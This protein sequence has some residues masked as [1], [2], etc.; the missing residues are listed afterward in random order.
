MNEVIEKSNGIDSIFEV[1]EKD[2]V[3]KVIENSEQKLILVDF[4]APWCG[5]CKQLGP[6]LEEIT[7]KYSE[8]ISLAKINID[9]NQQLAAQLRIQS[10]P[11]VIAFKDKK[12]ADG[13][14]GVIPKKNIIEFIEK[15][16]G[17]SLEKN[18]NEFYDKV[19]NLISQNEILQAVN[20]LEDFISKNS[21]D[22]KAIHFYINSLIELKKFD[23]AENFINSLSDE[24]LKNKEIQQSITN[25]EMKQKISSSPSVEELIKIY[26]NE[27]N[28]IN[29]LLMLSDRY[30][31][32]KD[33]EKAFELLMENFIKSKG[34]DRERIKKSFLKY[35]EALG[36]NHEHTKTYR[37][38]LSSFLFA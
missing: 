8:V 22:T 35:F 26:V 3:S 34:P 6:L 13:F 15:I 16:L 21:D 7:N 29:N 1:S 5:P 28:N 25:L 19:N 14:Q 24:I 33:T 18:N 36:D 37:R 12:I 27:P 11:T 23:D 38:K 2:F 30:F 9:E 10:I 20:L 17:G 4:W 32:E 31:A